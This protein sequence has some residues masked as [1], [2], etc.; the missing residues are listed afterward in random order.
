MKTLPNS[1]FF[2]EV[3]KLLAEGK[4]VML[5]VQGNSMRPFIRSGRT[6][7]LLSTCNP[8]ELKKGDIVL[9]RFRGRHILHRIVKRN[10]REFLLAGDGNYKIFERCGLDDIVAKA[11]TVI[12]PNGR[13]I[14]CESRLWRFGSGCWTSLHPF[15]RRC[16]LA[17]LWRVGIK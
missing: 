4:N 7:V 17:F 5:T 14:D 13:E 9:F 11:V 3:E 2:A 1:I 15:I 8:T 16:I 10:E 6:K 12:R